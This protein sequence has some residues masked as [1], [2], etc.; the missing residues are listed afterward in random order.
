MNGLLSVR[1]PACGGEAEVDEQEGFLFCT[2][3]GRIIAKENSI[4][5]PYTLAQLIEIGDKAADDGDSVAL[6]D[7]IEMLSSGYS[8]Q[9][10]LLYLG[11]LSAINGRTDLAFDVWGLL[12]SFSNDKEDVRK[13]F[14]KIISFMGR[15]LIEE[16]EKG[17]ILD[18]EDAELVSYSYMDRMDPGKE[19]WENIPYFAEEVAKAALNNASDIDGKGFRDTLM[20]N[21]SQLYLQMIKN[22]TDLLKVLEFCDLA[23]S[24]GNSLS[25][26]DT[27]DTG[28]KRTVKKELDFFQYLKDTVNGGISEMSDK[29]L[30]DLEE[31]WFTRDDDT[32]FPGEILEEAYI[33]HAKCDTS[34]SVKRMFIRNRWKKRIGKYLDCMLRKTSYQDRISPS[35]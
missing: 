25:S 26:P 35:H 20:A 11:Y 3:C 1:C 29:E 34:S 19:T 6:R 18:M 30:S 33:D 15:H 31:Y 9:T 28:N 24:A 22:D 16:S 23:I 32:P 13:M 17:N 8:S 14:P 12:I 10:S 21:L 4:P 5:V 7:T 27:G 2:R